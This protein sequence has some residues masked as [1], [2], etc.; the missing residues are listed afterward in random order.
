MKQHPTFSKSIMKPLVRF[1]EY[2]EIAG[3]HHEHWNGKG[4]PEGI[5]GEDIHLLARIVA[6]ADAWDAMVGDR[7]YRKGMP[8]QTALDILDREKDDGQFDPQL[9][10][11]FID[12][13]REEQ[14][15]V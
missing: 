3:S 12:L 6:I 8:V 2:A 4:Y 15:G 14:T 10:R 11:V 1:E 7:V 13:I 9:I 5:A